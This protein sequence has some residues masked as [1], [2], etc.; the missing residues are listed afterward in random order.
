MKKEFIKKVLVEGCA[1]TR[2]Y[3]YVERGDGIYRIE[4][5]RLETEAVPD[6]AWE[7]VYEL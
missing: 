4:R 1:T 5:Y 6:S 3:V 2:K 7:K